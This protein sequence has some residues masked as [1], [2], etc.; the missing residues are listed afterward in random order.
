MLLLILHSL[1]D[2]LVKYILSKNFISPYKL[3]FYQS[4][5]AIVLTFIIAF[6]SSY[7]LG[8][9]NSNI[10]CLGTIFENFREVSIEINKNKLSILY[11]ILLLISSIGYNT[12]SLLTIYYYTPTY[13]YVTENIALFLMIFINLIMN[14]GSIKF[15]AYYFISILG[16][17]FLLIGSFI[18]NE[19][20]ILHF[21]RLNYNIKEEIEKRAST[22]GMSET[23]E[24]LPSNEEQFS[25]N[26]LEGINSA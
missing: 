19:I 1:K 21:W 26:S 5:I 16:G 25:F 4:S 18:F 22:E 2:V 12:F 11:I 8:D 20:I 24:L 6:I 10:K 15:D 23:N 17:I 13:I 3:L 14:Y 9:E 7:T